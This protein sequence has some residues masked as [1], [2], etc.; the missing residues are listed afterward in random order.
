[1]GLAWRQREG[2]EERHTG[3]NVPRWVG[4]ELKM[5]QVAGV[6]GSEGPVEGEARV[7]AGRVLPALFQSWAFRLR[8]RGAF[9]VE[10]RVLSARP[11]LSDTALLLREGGDAGGQR[12]R[13]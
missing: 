7:G 9:G 12:R 3:L 1:M 13:V 2:R 4:R 10:S 6:R 8:S 11:C 5:F